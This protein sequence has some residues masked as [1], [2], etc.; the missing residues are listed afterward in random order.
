MS[1]RNSYEFNKRIAQRRHLDTIYDKNIDLMYDENGNPTPLRKLINYVI[2]KIELNEFDYKFIGGIN[3]EIRYQR[4]L[5][6]QRTLKPISKKKKKN[7]KSH[8]NWEANK[9]ARLGQ[10]RFLR[11]VQEFYRDDPER[12]RREE[13]RRYREE[14]NVH[15][16][17]RNIML[18]FIRMDR[19]HIKMRLLP[20]YP[21]NSQ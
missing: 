3:N 20:Y 10:E 8:K 4:R 19:R 6:E 11:A 21:E 18:S 5:K 1:K 13:E 7:K 9:K 16:C 12:A 2:A 15:N 14:E 17:Y